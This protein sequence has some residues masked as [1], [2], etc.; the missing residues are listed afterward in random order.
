MGCLGCL[1]RPH[2]SSDVSTAWQRHQ[3]LHHLLDLEGDALGDSHAHGRSQDAVSADLPL[4]T[5]LHH[6]T[7]E[8]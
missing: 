7:E 5:V 2:S 8:T 6:S 1:W 4:G 3:N